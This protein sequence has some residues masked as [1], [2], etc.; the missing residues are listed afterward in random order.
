MVADVTIG[1]VKDAKHH[2]DVQGFNVYH[3]NRLIK[4]LFFFCTSA[5]T[6]TIAFPLL[7]Y[8]FDVSMVNNAGRTHTL[9]VISIL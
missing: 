7:W 4:V 6:I 9:L 5:A 8:V 1:F 2:I 3:Q